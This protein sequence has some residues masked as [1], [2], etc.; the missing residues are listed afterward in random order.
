[1]LKIA[2]AHTNN[3]LDEF[4][5]CKDFFF[6]TLEKEAKAIPKPE[7]IKAE[8]CQS[9]IGK[10]FQLIDAKI[11]IL[12]V[13]EIDPDDE[14]VLNNSEIEV[15]KMPGQDVEGIPHLKDGFINMLKEL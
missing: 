4:R 6:Y 1:M 7:I 8:G 2:L 12:I 3:K 9:I 10:T 14:I 15:R 5:Q 11:N 13:S